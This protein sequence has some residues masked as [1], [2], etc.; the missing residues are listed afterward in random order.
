VSTGSQAFADNIL[1]HL[2]ES[3]PSGWTLVT[4]HEPAPHPAIF[5]AEEGDAITVVQP[6]GTSDHY[7]LTSAEPTAD[8]FGV[9]FHM[10]PAT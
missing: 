7:R 2:T 3:P 4:A 9:T 10:E 8:G 6:D 1:R 5:A